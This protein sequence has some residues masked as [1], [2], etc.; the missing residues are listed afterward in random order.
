MAGSASD[1]TFQS[2]RIA[3]HKRGVPPTPPI[4]FSQS[5]HQM[6]L[7]RS[8]NLSNLLPTHSK[9]RNSYLGTSQGSR[10][11]RISKIGE[12]LLEASDAD[13]NSNH[14]SIRSNN[15]LLG[16][17]WVAELSH[18]SP[19]SKLCS[20]SGHPNRHSSSAR[21]SLLRH[22]V[23]AYSLSKLHNSL[24]KVSSV[25]SRSNS[26]QEVE[27]FLAVASHMRAVVLDS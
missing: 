4:P 6:S 20:K 1:R 24:D 7:A 19:V 17:G 22:L 26:N 12:L 14:S 9:H 13:C 16:R 5:S 27:V 2:Q 25:V 8:F 11:N 15:H 21:C 23:V 10:T 18:F 3:R